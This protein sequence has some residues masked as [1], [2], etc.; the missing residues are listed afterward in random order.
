MAEATPKAEE[1]AKEKGVDLDSVKGSG[2]DGRVLIEDVEA[3]VETDASE[4]EAQEKHPT[5]V[6]GEVGDHDLVATPDEDAAEVPAADAHELH[7]H[8]P[9]AEQS[10]QELAELEEG[11]ANQEGE[12]AEEEALSPGDDPNQVSTDDI[13]NRG[14]HEKGFYVIPPQV[15]PIYLAS[16]EEDSP[17]AA[18]E[19]DDEDVA[20]AERP[21]AQEGVVD[22]SSGGEAPSHGESLKE[23]SPA[24]ADVTEKGGP[25][26]SEGSAGDGFKV[27]PA[28]DAKNEDGD[29]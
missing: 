2:K 21:A 5:E 4:P 29:S 19:V 22:T 20:E 3:A 17:Y 26:T 16:L 15:N 14:K 18:T 25:G 8:V 28:E 10:D 13:L 11:L 6:V 7:P 24:V 9:Y 27:H 12:E 1:L 23:Q